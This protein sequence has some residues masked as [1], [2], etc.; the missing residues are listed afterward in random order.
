MKKLNRIVE[1]AI[2]IVENEDYKKGLQLH[3]DTEMAYLWLVSHLV[4]RGGSSSVSHIYYCLAMDEEGAIAQTIDNPFQG[5]ESKFVGSEQRR[6]ITSSA[7]RV[8]FQIRGWGTD[9]F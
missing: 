5:N 7:V 6:T 3:Q 8:P 4:E 2:Q 9:T 1:N